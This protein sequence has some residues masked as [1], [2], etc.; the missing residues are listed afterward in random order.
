MKRRSLWLP[1]AFV[2]GFLA[3]GLPYWQ[4]PYAKLGLPD[5]LI[6][7]GLLVVAAAALLTRAVGGRSLPRTIA[8][9]GASVPCAVMARVIV[10]AV[11]DPTSHNLWPIEVVIALVLGLCASAAGALLG[12]LLLRAPGAGASD[13]S[14]R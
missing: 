6:G 11:Q 8:L 2:A 14:E 1:L 9:V 12:S 4:I 5:A 13:E 7:P 3:V 10:D